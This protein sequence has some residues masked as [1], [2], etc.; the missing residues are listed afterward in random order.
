M[1]V[2]KDIKVVGK[3]GRSFL[4]DVYLP[5]NDGVFPVVVFAHGFKGFKDWGHWHAIAAEFVKEG[6]AFVTFNFSHNGTTLEQ[7]S[8]FADLVAFG[9]NNYSKE[10]DDL[11]VV[12]D[13]VEKDPLFSS[14][15]SLIGHSRGG[16]LSVVKTAKDQ[17]IKNLITWASV[18]SLGYVFEG[19]AKM[20]EWRSEGVHYIINGRT[21]QRMPLFYQLYEDYIKNRERFNT[22]DAAAAINVPWLIIHGS[23]DPAVPEVHAHKLH[24]WSKD[25]RV[26]II[27]DANHVFGGRHPYKSDELPPHSRQLA[28]LSI[29]F[30]KN[31]NF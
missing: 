26:S 17:R 18:S 8:D 6:F 14:N 4:M 22:K 20:E 30:L 13:Y 19:Q 16:G 29:N 21:G 28:S 25:A 7:P 27:Q 12:L 3:H 1:N 11:D 9:R 24:E 10:W 15:I 31:Q 2:R 23:D 5:D